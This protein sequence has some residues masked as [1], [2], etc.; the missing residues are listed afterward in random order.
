LRTL[1]NM[2][3][4]EEIIGMSDEQI[5]AEIRARGGDPKDI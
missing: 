4:H 3:A 2:E 1:E 5:E